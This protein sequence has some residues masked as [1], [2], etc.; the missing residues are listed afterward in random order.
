MGNSSILMEH[1]KEPFEEV[2]GILIDEQIAV[3]QATT[4]SGKSY[5]GLEL[6]AY[7]NYNALIVVPK[8][9]IGYQWSKLLFKYKF[10]DS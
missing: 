4:G 9:D 7:T 2:L 8:D 1:N 6:I 3:Y 5:I 10:K